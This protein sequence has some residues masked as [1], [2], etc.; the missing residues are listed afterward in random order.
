MIRLYWKRLGRLVVSPIW[1]RFEGARARAPAC[2]AE[3]QDHGDPFMY[4]VVKWCG[5]PEG[6]DPLVVQGEALVFSEVEVLK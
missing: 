1:S 3:L 2:N 6:R 5:S 4:G